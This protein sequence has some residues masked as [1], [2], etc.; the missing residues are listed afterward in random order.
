MFLSIAFLVGSTIGGIATISGALV[1]GLF[2]EFVPNFAN[3]ISDAAPAALYGLAML[4]FMYAMPLG[5]IGSLAPLVS[6][7]LRQIRTRNG[8]VALS[9]KT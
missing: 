3:D 8:A 2:I 1:G 9:D 5:V 7:W 4:L 6:R